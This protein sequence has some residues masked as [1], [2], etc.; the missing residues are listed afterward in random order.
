MTAPA[1]RWPLLWVDPRIHATECAR[2][3]SFVAIGPTETDCSIWIGAIGGDG[4]GRFYITRDGKGRCVRPNRFAL[5]RALRRPLGPDSLAL[6][7][8][9][10]P[11]CVKIAPEGASKLHVVDGDQ[12]DNMIR[13]ARTRRGGGRWL[14]RRDHVADRRAKSVALR[15]A[16]R[17]GW[18]Q[19]AITNVLQR[20]AEP[21][22]FDLTQLFTPRSKGAPDECE[23]H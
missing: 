18:D 17:N 23:E 9:D 15:D 3:D 13:M 16:A 5:A 4:Y 2:F 7:E 20:A 22:L 8:C 21:G 11:L 6:H 19:E 14:L 12:R 10:N 1:A